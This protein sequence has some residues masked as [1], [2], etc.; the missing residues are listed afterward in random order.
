MFK[1]KNLIFKTLMSFFECQV[2]PD[3]M[4]NVSFN[5]IVVESKVITPKH[6]INSINIG[7]SNRII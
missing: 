6:V 7:C 3:F 4:K 5:L 2:T 1:Y